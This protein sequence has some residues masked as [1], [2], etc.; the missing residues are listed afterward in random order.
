MLEK[1]TDR[2]LQALNG[3]DLFIALL[4]IAFAAGFWYVIEARTKRDRRKILIQI[5]VA[6]VLL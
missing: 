1:L 4:A 3:A 6:L 5:A 2:I